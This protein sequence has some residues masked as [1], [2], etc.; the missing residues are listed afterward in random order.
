MDY[1]VLYL[2]VIKPL[3]HR[4]TKLTSHFCCF[5]NKNVLIAC[6]VE[7]EL[8]GRGATK[9]SP[10]IELNKISMVMWVSYNS[11]LVSSTQ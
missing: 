1:F 11:E 3:I 6:P 5:P 4:P 2:P 7:K 9:S 8:I 10:A